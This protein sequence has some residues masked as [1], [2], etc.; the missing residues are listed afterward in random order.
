MHFK[1]YRL[2]FKMYGEM[3]SRP[4]KE[5]LSTRLWLVGGGWVG[6]GRMSVRLG[7]KRSHL[8]ES[9]DWF[10]SDF[11]AY[12]AAARLC[13]FFILGCLHCV[14]VVG[15]AET[16]MSSVCTDVGPSADKK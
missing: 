4:L 7:R 12:I 16:E 8:A 5:Q 1:M 11:R 15:A 6:N 10:A 3:Y 14:W 9:H 2:H 13:A